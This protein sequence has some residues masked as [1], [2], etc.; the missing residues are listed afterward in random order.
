MSE[1]VAVIPEH[2]E[3]ATNT[4]DMPGYNVLTAAASIA[5]ER[6]NDTNA[7]TEP[8]S[9]AE[10][11]PTLQSSGYTCTCDPTNEVKKC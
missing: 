6:W 5:V 10:Q 1:H 2:Q 8:A 11:T 7:T 9:G 3:G 4:Y